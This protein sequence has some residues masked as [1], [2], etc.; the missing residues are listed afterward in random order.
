MLAMKRSSLR[1]LAK[2]SFLLC[3]LALLVAG[4]ILAWFASWRSDKLAAL[5]LASE[6]AETDKGKVEVLDSGRGPDG[7][8]FSWN[9]RR[10]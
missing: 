7:A 2:V 5:D 8:G 9:A 3:V 4:F 10:V 1:I 6:I